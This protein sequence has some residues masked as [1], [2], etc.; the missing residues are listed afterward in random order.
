MLDLELAFLDRRWLEQTVLVPLPLRPLSP[1]V[2]TGWETGWAQTGLSCRRRPLGWLPCQTRVSGGC[3]RYSNPIPSFRP[4]C[5]GELRLCW[6]GVAWVRKSPGAPTSCSP[7]GC[8]R[9][10]AKWGLGWGFQDWPAAETAIM[11]TEG[12]ARPHRHPGSMSGPRRKQM[13]CSDEGNLGTVTRLVGRR[14]GSYKRCC[15]TRGPPHSRADRADGGA[16]TLPDRERCG[17]P[18]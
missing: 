11:S 3:A 7:A 14:Q 15:R 10:P 16:L 5:R 13:A 12:C 4:F 1:P 9:P 17:E 8:P 2:G 6:G 18:T